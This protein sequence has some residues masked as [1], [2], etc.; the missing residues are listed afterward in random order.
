MNEEQKQKLRDA[1]GE[2]KTIQ[3]CYPHWRDYHPEHGGDVEVDLNNRDM[4][5]QIKPAPQG[6]VF[7]IPK[8]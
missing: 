2:G 4:E 7:E 5:W 8:I 3:F 6:V 1:M